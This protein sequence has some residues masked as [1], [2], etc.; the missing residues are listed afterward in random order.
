M[1][2]VPSFK[3]RLIV[4]QFQG[5]YLK[6]KLFIICCLEPTRTRFLANALAKDII[7]NN[8]RRMKFKLPYLVISFGF[9]V[10]ALKGTFSI[11][12]ADGSAERCQSHDRR[13]TQKQS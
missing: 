9:T 11:H 1:L 4:E 8:T 12:T 5:N 10:C 2:T 6:E 3:K 13:C 7:P